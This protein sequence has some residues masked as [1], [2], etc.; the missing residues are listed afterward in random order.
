LH[1]FNNF[2]LHIALKILII[3][4]YDSFTFNLAHYIEGVTGEDVEVIR[5]DLVKLNE[6]SK[7]DKIVISPGP[8]LPKQSGLLMEALVNIPDNTPVLAICLGMQAYAE[9]GGIPLFNLE[10]TCHG[11]SVDCKLDTGFV[12]F[13]GLPDSTEVGLYHS[14]A[15]RN[16]LTEQWKATAISSSGILM[17]MSH[18]R[19]PIHCVQFHPES[20]LTPEGKNM[21]MNFINRT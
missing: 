13:K 12:L 16:D 15:V 20:V 5:N 3:D 18:V 4:N 19:K 14:W 17:G 11:I 7:Y 9:L 8:G 6:L 1:K 2:D 10:N 21:V